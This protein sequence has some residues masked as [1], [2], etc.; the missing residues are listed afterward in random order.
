MGLLDILRGERRP[1]RANLDN[2]FALTTAEPT[3]RT[4]LDMVPLERAGVCF[5]PV[6]MGAFDELLSDLEQIL[7]L[8]DADGQAIERTVDDTFGFRWIVLRGADLSDLVTRAHLVNQTLEERG[9]SEQLLCSVFGIHPESGGRTAYLVYLYKRGTFYPFVPTG[10]HQRDNVAELRL[11][12]TLGGEMPMEP[13]LERWY[14][15]W[16]VPVGG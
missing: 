4:A 12:A 1:K 8:P 6:T 14:P 15:L 16:D 9:F 3:I 10:D 11:K 2:L 13:E 5:K 7:S